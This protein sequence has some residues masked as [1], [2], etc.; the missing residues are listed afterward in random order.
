MGIKPDERKAGGRNRKHR[1]EQPRLPILR[2]WKRFKQT[3]I[4]PPTAPLKRVFS[5]AVSFINVTVKRFD[6]VRSGSSGSMLQSQLEDEQPPM[7]AKYNT[8]EDKRTESHHLVCLCGGL[9]G[10]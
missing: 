10:E 4:S 8:S 1:A 2:L 3:G 5:S 6:C 9:Y 7:S